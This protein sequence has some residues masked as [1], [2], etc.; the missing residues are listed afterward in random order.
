MAWYGAVEFHRGFA[1]CDSMAEPEQP[2]VGDDR[3]AIAV[4]QERRLLLDGGF[5]ARALRSATPR[6]GQRHAKL[7]CFSQPGFPRRV[8]PCKSFGIFHSSGL[9]TISTLMRQE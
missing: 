9:R 5:E 3:S 8:R 7:P 4:R 1:L 2:Q 6:D